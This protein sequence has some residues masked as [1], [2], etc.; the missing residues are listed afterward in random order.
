MDKLRSVGCVIFVLLAIGAFFFVKDFK[1]KADAKAEKEAAAYFLSLIREDTSTDLNAG[2][3]KAPL[4]PWILAS[5]P[6]QLELEDKVKLPRSMDGDW[7]KFDIHYDPNGGDNP[8]PLSVRVK[9]D[10]Q[11]LSA[12]SGF[13]GTVGRNQ[14]DWVPPNN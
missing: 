3:G 14:L 13:H 4:H 11:G 10:Q 2:S 7:F 5:N 6:T 12:M 9:F 1:Q 8:P